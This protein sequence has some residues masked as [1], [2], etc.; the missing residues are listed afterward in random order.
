M[1]WITLQDSMNSNDLLMLERPN[2]AEIARSVAGGDAARASV[3]GRWAERRWFASGYLKG[4]SYGSDRDIQ[5][6]RGQTGFIGRVAGRPYTDPDIACIA[7]FRAPTPSPSGGRPT[8]GRCA[9][10]TGRS[11]ASTSSA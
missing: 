11:C 3:G 10:A 8:A 1:P 2:I 9:C 7:A 5:A 6:T 4:D